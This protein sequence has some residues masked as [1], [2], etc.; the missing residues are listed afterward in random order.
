MKKITTRILAFILVFAMAFPIATALT[1]ETTASAA[2]IAL[3]A[4]KKTVVLG[5]TYTVTLKDSS[6]VSKKSFKSS[7]TKIATVNGK[8]VVTPVAQGTAIIKCTATLKTGVTVS[9]TCKITVKKRVPA[10][11]LS[12]KNLVHDKINAHI[13]E[14][15]DSYDFNVKLTPTDSTDTS[16]FTIADSDIASVSA[17]G[18]VS[19]KKEGITV[20]E[21]RAGLNA[22]EAKNSTAIAKTYIYVVPKTIVTPPPTPTPTPVV[23]PEA[24]KVNMVGSQEL[25]VKFNTQIA[26]SSVID[27]NNKLIEGAITITPGNGAN[28]YGILTARLSEDKTTVSISSTGEFNGTYVVTVFN[29]VMSMDGQLVEPASFQIDFK[30]LVGPSYV[31]SEITDSGY[32]CKINFS[33]A[34]DIS[35]LQIISVAGT[36]NQT[37]KSR[38][39]T[40]SNYILSTDKKSLTIDLSSCGEKVINVM[41]GM[42]GIKDVKGNVSSPYTLNAIVECDGTEKPVANVIDVVRESK[43]TLVATFDQPIQFGGYAI[44]DGSYLTGVVDSN[45]PKLVRYT[46]TNT[47]LVGTKTVVFSNYRNFNMVNS[48]TNNQTRAVDFT[49]DTTAPSITGYEIKSEILNQVTV[50]SLELTFDKNISVINVSGTISALVNSINGD[51]YTKSLGYTAVAKDKKLILTFNGQNLESGFYT[52][53]IPGGL[54]MDALENLSAPAKISISNQIGSNN[55]LP[56]PISIIQDGT[57]PSKVIVTF[58]NKL[59]TAS[60]QLVTNYKINGSIIPTSASIV[61]QSNS[62]AVVE[63]IFNSGAFTTNG[64]YTITVSGIKGYNGTYGEMNVYNTVLTLINNNSPEVISCKLTHSGLI[65]LTLSKQ[66]TGTGKFQVYTSGGFVDASSVFTS[67]NII[68]ITLPTTTTSETY[69]KLVTNEF[70]DANNNLANIP[71]QILAEKAY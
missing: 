55:A 18:I 31:N 65:Q 26:K 16:Y 51:I 43:T 8:G 3:T 19:A 59:D 71:S 44:V 6:N 70:R 33:E 46:L 40:A 66:V 28:S 58:S 49:L 30:D 41:V 57:I 63:L 61:E 21:A 50:P 17:S 2:A 7:N 20:L 35:N 13:I 48:S 47:S 24:T 54:V 34:I 42:I 45:N 38:L 5:N 12:F 15:G 25:Q 60:A 53:T 68:Y 1:P 32:I 9:A 29:K 69:L 67:G 39:T 23:K 64:I 56:Q 36:N 27:G 10:R 62:N 4:T 52:F 37:V 11:E 22:T 14:V